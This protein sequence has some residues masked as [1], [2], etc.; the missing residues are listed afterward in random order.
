[1]KIEGVNS[2][3]EVINSALTSS[4]W[5]VNLTGYA[6]TSPLYG[7]RGINLAVCTFINLIALLS[8]NNVQLQI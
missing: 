1:M 4:H 7:S 8:D 2:M 5:A 3:A 6:M